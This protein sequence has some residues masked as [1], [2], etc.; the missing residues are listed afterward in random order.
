MNRIAWVLFMA[1]RYLKERRSSKGPAAGVLSTAGIALGVVTLVVVIGVMNGFQLGF[2]EDILEIRSYDLQVSSLDLQTASAAAEK[3]RS[4][5]AVRA[6]LPFIET[7]T[8][9]QGRFSEFEAAALR[10]I[11]ANAGELD[12]GLVQQLSVDQGDFN[13]AE[14]LVLGRELARALGVRIGDTVT[15]AALT[16]EGFA[17]LVPSSRELPVTGTFHSGFYEYDRGLVFTSLEIIRDLA[18]V[19][20]RP[21]V[22][23]KLKNRYRI[24]AALDTLKNEF[25]SVAGYQEQGPEIV[26]W[27]ESNRAFFGALR[28]EKLIMSLLIGVMFLVTAGNIYHSLRRGVQEKRTAI[29]VLRALGGGRREIQ[30]IFVL[31]G[32]LM[33][34]AGTFWGLSLGLLL[35]NHINRLFVLLEILSEWTA[36]LLNTLFGIDALGGL[37]ITPAAFYMSEVPVRILPL[38]IF[39]IAFFALFVSLFSAWGASRDIAGMNPSTILRYE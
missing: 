10:G 1:R 29:A 20:D 37:A 35:V 16:G 24:D 32:G 18:S 3:A 23:I 15:L 30:L 4:V 9:V 2:I 11:P 36:G 17:G 7:Q 26:S 12:P 31:E 39:L 38:E 22:G 33:G 21:A 13:L 8:L 25:D 28:M 14:G 5:S 27:R 6:A 19:N 34:L